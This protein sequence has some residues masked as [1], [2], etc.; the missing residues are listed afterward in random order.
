MVEMY[1]DT[2]WRS[3]RRLGV[4]EAA[5]DDG[6][7]QVFLIASRRLDEIEVGGERGYLLGIALRIASEMR[8]ALGRRREVPLDAAVVDLSFRGARHH[9]PDEMLEHKQ[10][11]TLLAEWL[12]EMPDKLKE[13]FV[14]FELEELNASEVARVLGVPV[15]T[16]AS[17]VRRAREHIRQSLANRGAP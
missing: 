10:L 12:D 1:F 17:R 13:A 5:A 6:A 9:L 3:L 7:Q 4:P 2:V 16:V 15:G 14:L 11:L 8:R